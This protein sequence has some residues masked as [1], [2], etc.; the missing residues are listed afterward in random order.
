MVVGGALFGWL[1]DRVGR[2]LMYTLDLAA[3]IVASAAQFRVRAPW[4]L[5]ARDSSSG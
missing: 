5:F 1:T 3:L 4:E 2:Q